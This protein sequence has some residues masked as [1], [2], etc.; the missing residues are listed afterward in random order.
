M[1]L[2]AEL[3]FF[4]CV[5]VL[6]V[7]MAFTSSDSSDITSNVS[8]SD[9]TNVS[10]SEDDDW[11]FNAAAI[12]AYAMLDNVTSSTKKARKISEETGYQWA[13]RHL[14]DLE[15]CYDMIRMRRSVFYSLHHVL[16]INYGLRSS[17]KMCS[18]EALGMFLWICGAPQS[19]CQAKHIFTHLKENVSR[20][21]NDVV[22]YVTQLA[23][24]N[25]KPEDP[26]FVVVHPKIREHR[27]W[28]HFRNCVGAIDGTHIEFT[29]PS[30]EQVVH[31][32]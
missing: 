19:V 14:R 26:T 25:I 5:Y 9:V 29:V 4:C 31:I 30:L 32:N 3:S 7:H 22:E 28:P 24:H 16:V 6:L 13:Q 20:R 23:A 21:F 12:A 15:N 17:N 2:V 11:M 8:Q 10:H 18:I 27:S 1:Y